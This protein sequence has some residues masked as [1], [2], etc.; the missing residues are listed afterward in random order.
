MKESYTTLVQ[1]VMK[2]EIY[3]LMTMREQNLSNQKLYC[4]TSLSNRKNVR[5]ELCGCFKYIERY[6]NVR[7]RELYNK[8]TS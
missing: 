4:A 5:G 3:L 8:R 1:E 7:K 6:G 2:E